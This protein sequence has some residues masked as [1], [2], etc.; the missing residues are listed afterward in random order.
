MG[1]INVPIPV[2]LLK[3][4]LCETVTFTFHLI[5]SLSGKS[6]CLATPNPQPAVGLNVGHVAMVMGLGPH[7]QQMVQLFKK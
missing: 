2:I 5:Y 1:G 4:E 6:R 7:V 3:V